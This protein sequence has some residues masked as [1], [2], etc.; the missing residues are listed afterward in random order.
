M[1]ADK[2]FQARGPATSNELLAVAGQTKVQPMSGDDDRRLDTDIHVTDKAV[3]CV[4][5]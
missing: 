2:L 4:E 3:Q 5:K 1:E